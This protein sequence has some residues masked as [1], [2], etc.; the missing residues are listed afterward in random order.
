MSGGEDTAQDRA[1]L[2]VASLDRDTRARV[3]ATIAR[4]FGDLDLAEDVTQEAL[5]QALV[6]WAERGVPDVPEAWL[7][8]TAK[9]KALDVV[10]RDR[11]LAEKVARLRIEED[12]SPISREL[13]DPAAL[14][15][16]EVPDPVGHADDQLGLYFA[17]AHP[18]VKPEDRI[19]L[20]LRFVAGLTTAEVA[21][22]LLTPVSTMQQRM[23]R[24]K[25][26]IRALGVS[27]A[28]PRPTE[29]EQRLAG[30]LRVV[31]LLYSEGFARSGGETHVRD[32]L[33]AEAIR[34]ARILRDLLPGHPET[35][36]LLALLLLTEARRPARVAADGTPVPLA[37]QNRSAWDRAQITEGLRLA[38]A[39][40]SSGR[41][42]GGYAIQAA[43]AAVHA[44]A[45]SFVDTD[46]AQVSVLYRLLERVEPGPVV[47][48]GAAVA[49]GRALGAATGLRRLEA[50]AADPEL[51]R[52]RP[53]HI[54]RAVTLSELGD[55]DAA[56]AA[57]RDALAL[58]GNSAEDAALAALAA[59]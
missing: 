56:A 11:V 13:R 30:V 45:R 20:T 5:A 1:R 12:R 8:T 34:L 17:C 59:L 19:S 29:L 16:L 23:V 55:A 48:L 3:L 35:T 9:R 10:R 47:R 15:E 52:F 32:D 50:L 25:T 18:A 6:A 44:E 27:F 4:W 14:A 42:A 49:A 40:A 36:G 38:E 33:T 54:A 46:W 28:P 21:H 51:A 37:E 7:K 57:Y 22:A 24:A 43:I 31:Y 53:F 39:A 26:R 58:P 41:R 2:A